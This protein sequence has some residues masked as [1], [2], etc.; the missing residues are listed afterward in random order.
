M[1]NFWHAC[2]AHDYVEKEVASLE[3]EYVGA[4][5]K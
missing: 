5:D 4:P 3:M 1:E 2:F